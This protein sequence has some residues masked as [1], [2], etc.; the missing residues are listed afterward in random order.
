MR[1]GPAAP[2]S[3]ME[4]LFLQT[5]L[6]AQ[7]EGYRWFNLGMVPLAGLEARASAPL[8]NRVGALAFR[9]GEHFYNFHGLRQ[10]KEKFHPE[11]RPK[12]LIYSGGLVLPHVLANVAALVWG[13]VGGVVTK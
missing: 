12:Y 11:W 9:Y 7:A 2:P 4:Y 6:W 13:G 3:V 5:M 8:W 1:Y 10:F